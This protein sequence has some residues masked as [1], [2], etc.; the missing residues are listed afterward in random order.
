MVMKNL[1]STI[2]VT[3][4][5]FLNSWIFLTWLKHFKQNVP[6]TVKS[7]MMM[8]YDKYN[9]KHNE[10][11]IEKAMKVKTIL[12]FLPANPTQLIESLDI[13]VFKAS[14]TVL[15]DK[16]MSL[17]SKAW[18]LPCPKKITIEKV[19]MSCIQAINYCCWIWG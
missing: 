19:S 7:T 18:W 10:E 8:V 12:V 6:D 11:I 16:S 1:G 17:W 9:R 5:G 14:K 4:K 2:S 15:T 3:Y 13:S